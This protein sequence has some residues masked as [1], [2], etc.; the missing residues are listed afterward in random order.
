MTRHQSQRDSEVGQSNGVI[1]NGLISVMSACHAAR[2]MQDCRSFQ[3]ANAIMLRRNCAAVMATFLTRRTC[4]S[5]Y[6]G[7]PDNL[8]LLLPD[9]KTTY[10]NLMKYGTINGVLY[11]A[12]QQAK[13][14]VDRHV[15]NTLFKD[16]RDSK[17]NRHSLITRI[18]RHVPPR[19][20]EVLVFSDL[21]KH[22]RAKKDL[23]YSVLGPEKAESFLRNWSPNSTPYQAMMIVRMAHNHEG[24]MFLSI[25]EFANAFTEKPAAIAALRG[26]CE[27]FLPGKNRNPPN[28]RRVHLCISVYDAVILEHLTTVS[29]RPQLM[30]SLTPVFPM[31][32]P[33]NR[34]A[35]KNLNLPWVE[36]LLDSEKRGSLRG[37][38]IAHDATAMQLFMKSGGHP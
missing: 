25:D 28:C 12:R 4:S 15:A 26:L 2:M 24:P 3:T 10:D 9:S 6:T 7:V 27:E 8:L 29:G 14:Q 20:A 16:I 23:F 19:D 17:R 37:A 18:L 36:T 38:S 34:H 35:I 31:Y 1:S 11:V 21:E 22:L 32:V 5:D 13:T 30:Q 33:S